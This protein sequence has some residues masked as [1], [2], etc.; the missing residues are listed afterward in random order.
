MLSNSE[1]SF[2]CAPM[3]SNR[4]GW[5]I[6]SSLPWRLV[7]RCIQ[8]LSP[9]NCPQRPILDQTRSCLGNPVQAV[10]HLCELRLWITRRISLCA[11]MF[12]HTSFSSEITMCDL[13]TKSELP[14]SFWPHKGCP[15]HCYQGLGCT[16]AWGRRRRLLT[17]GALKSTILNGWAFLPTPWGLSG[18]GSRSWGGSEHTIPLGLGFSRHFCDPGTLMYH[19]WPGMKKT[20]LQFTCNSLFFWL[21]SILCHVEYSDFC[22]ETNWY[23]HIRK[24]SKHLIKRRKH[25]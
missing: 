4:Q 14:A 10:A 20:C 5:H 9:L 2:Y 12:K 7:V 11:D 6:P 17:L 21:L 22:E 24:S 23:E 15:R 16:L 18:R 8:A 1:M 25:F 19:Y 3:I 13:R